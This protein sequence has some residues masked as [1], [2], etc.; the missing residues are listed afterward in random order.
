MT[1]ISDR[2]VLFVYNFTPSIY[3]ELSCLIKEQK[4]QPFSIKNSIS[5]IFHFSPIFQFFCIFSLIFV[6]LDNKK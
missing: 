4:K 3:K 6:V 5:P 2:D 1:N